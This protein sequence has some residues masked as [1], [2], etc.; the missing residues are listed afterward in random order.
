MN[1]DCCPT[2]TGLQ[3]SRPNRPLPLRELLGTVGLRYKV[4]ALHTYQAHDGYT[5]QEN[6]LGDYVRQG[7]PGR[8]TRRATVTS[9]VRAPSFRLSVTDGWDWRFGSYHQSLTSSCGR[10]SEIA[11]IQVLYSVLHEL[12]RLGC[13]TLGGGTDSSAS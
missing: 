12:T 6:K 9:P 5:K 7:R 3:H 1:T 10:V 4:T 11:V 13:L 2:D 8:A